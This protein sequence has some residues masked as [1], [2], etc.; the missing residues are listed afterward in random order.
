MAF[1]ACTKDELSRS[2]QGS[3]GQILKKA[4][5]Y[6]EQDYLVFKSIES[7]DSLKKVLDS[8]S[9]DSRLAFEQSMNFTSTANYRSMAN[10]K[11]MEFTSEE[12]AKPFIAQLAEK[13]YF[14][15]KDSCL[16]YPFKMISWESILNPKGLIKINSVLYCFQKDKQIC[17]MDGKKETLESFLNGQIEAD[18]INI[19]VVKYATNQLCGY[20]FGNAIAEVGR[21]SGRYKLTV[22]LIYDA[23]YM[24]NDKVWVDK[25]Y[26]KFYF[27]QQKKSIAWWNDSRTHFVYYPN[28]MK[29][30]GT[31]QEYDTPWANATY[32]DT[33]KWYDMN[34]DEAFANVYYQIWESSIYPCRYDGGSNGPVIQ[35]N[36][37]FYSDDVGSNTDPIY[38]IISY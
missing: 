21:A 37:M 11:L 34:K 5:V 33:P 2:D 15:L 20:W 4:D 3:K 31:M 18:D 16:T 29:F 35:M 19:K 28:Q 12:Q 9:E 25:A 8:K 1:G 26:Y 27:H 22:Q 24:P 23:I 14:N 6:A 10:D 30:G 7:V 36:A 32:G 17:I 13:G 38:M